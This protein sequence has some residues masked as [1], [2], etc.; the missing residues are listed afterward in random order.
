[1]L[2]VEEIIELTGEKA[3]SRSVVA[4]HWPMTD[5]RGADVLVLVELAA[6]TAGI[7]NGW[8]NR[9][10]N[11]PDAVSRGWIVGVK[12]ARFSVDVLPLGAEIRVTSENSFEFEGFRE[13]R[14]SAK[15]N[16]RSA[17]EIT[18]Q[19]MQADQDKGIYQ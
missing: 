15:V 3:V 12:S 5:H 1:M 19:L 7:N 9:L 6:Q 4:A 18:L 10:R 16:G 13:I 11:G 2:L 14:S 8:Q 17:A